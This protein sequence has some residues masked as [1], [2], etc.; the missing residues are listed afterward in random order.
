M[1]TIQERKVEVEM[2]EPAVRVLEEMALAYEQPLKVMV[3]QMIYMMMECD[4]TGSGD[5]SDEL[6]KYLCRKHGYNPAA[7]R[8]EVS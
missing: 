8:K 5:M 2:P 6:A 7:W 1:S 4:L 3:K